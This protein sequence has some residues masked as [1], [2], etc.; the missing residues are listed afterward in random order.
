MMAGRGSS[1]EALVEGWGFGFRDSGFGCKVQCSGSHF[2]GLLIG[3]RVPGLGSSLFSGFECR[4]P[5]S[6]FRIL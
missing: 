5:D 4:V 6:G 1:F 3:V 2:S